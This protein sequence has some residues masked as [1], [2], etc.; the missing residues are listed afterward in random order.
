MHACEATSFLPLFS[1]EQGGREVPPWALI[2]NNAKFFHY[3][4]GSFRFHVLG[5]LVGGIV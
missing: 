5:F 4:S 2:F 3:N 1:L